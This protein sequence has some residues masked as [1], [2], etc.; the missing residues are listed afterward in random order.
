MKN[1]EIYTDG[2][3]LGNPGPG[4]WASV[5]LSKE[6]EGE[7]A[8]IILKG[9]ETNATNN[10][11]EMT[12]IAEALNW[13]QEHGPKSAH[14]SLYS[15]SELIVNSLKEG[16]KRKANLDLWRK[17]DK[18]KKGLDI[19]WIWVKG[20]SDNE[21]NNTCD[22]L[23]VSEAEK[24]AE[25]SKGQSIGEIAFKDEDGYFCGKCNKKIDGVLGFMPDSEMIRVE[26]PDCGTYIM[27]AEKTKK[28]LA[29]AKKRVLVS[30]KQL[31]EV[32]K[33]KEDRGEVV[34]ENEMK[35][36]KSWTE[37]EALRFLRENQKL[38]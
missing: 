17:L 21:W 8:R 26:C 27:F 33:L 22:K 14:F 7:K 29:K 15:D 12:A 3:S 34:T 20:H 16:W 38:F 11:M 1:I 6:E 10:R 19:E 9:G 23:A 37:K 2:S 36:L 18:A 32:V 28:N 24:I 25:E 31:E 35:K 5:I 30:K 13:I 4:G